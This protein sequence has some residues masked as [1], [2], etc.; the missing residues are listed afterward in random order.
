MFPIQ[1]NSFFIIIFNSFKLYYNL[2]INS[3]FYIWGKQL[4]WSSSA[5]YVSHYQYQPIYL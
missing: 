2:V 5:F 1:I 4:N 3:T